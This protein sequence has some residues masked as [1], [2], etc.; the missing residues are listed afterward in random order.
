MGRPSINFSLRVI[1]A[2]LQGCSFFLILCY[3]PQCHQSATHVPHCNGFSLFVLVLC[4]ICSE[5]NNLNV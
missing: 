5:G 4:Y 2:L 3:Q 1:T